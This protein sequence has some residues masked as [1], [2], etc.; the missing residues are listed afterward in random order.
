[1]TTFQ[2]KMINKIFKF[3][4]EINGLFTNGIHYFINVTIDNEDYTFQIKYDTC[5]IMETCDM[6]NVTESMQIET[7]KLF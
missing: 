6:I 4:F 3:G 1:M 5:V 2:A 7:I